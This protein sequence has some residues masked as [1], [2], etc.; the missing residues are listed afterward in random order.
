MK[1]LDICQRSNVD[2]PEHLKDLDILGIT[3]NSRGVKEGYLFVCL[4]GKKTDGHR[5]INDALLRGAVAVVIEKQSFSFDRSITVGDTRA[6]LAKMMNA[7][8]G[9]PTKHL[10]FIAV[11]GTNGKTSVAVMIK[12]IFDKANIPCEVIGTLN[13]SSFLIRSCD[14]TANFTT[15]DPEELYPM[16]R[17]ISDGGIKIVIMEASSHALKLKK[18]EPIEF[19]R[20]CIHNQNYL[21]YLVAISQ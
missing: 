14:S 7:F 17:R 5:Y 10:K 2:C 9:E 19:D 21:H 4:D 8:C 16:L 18:L 15:P 6:T 12:N 3:S 20:K 1:L 11:T 13:Q